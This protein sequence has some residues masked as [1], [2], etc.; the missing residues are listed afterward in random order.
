[1]TPHTSPL[2]RAVDEMLLDAGETDARLRATLLSLG[3]LASLPV[4]EPRAD[5]AALLA[6]QPSLLAR[7]RL[8]RSRRSAAVGL[9]VI[10]GM[11]LGVTGVAATG[12]APNPHASRSIQHLMQDWAPSWTVAGTPAALGALGDAPRMP[13]AE[14][15]VPEASVPDGSGLDES[16]PGGPVPALSDA[17]DQ[18]TADLGTPGPATGVPGGVAQENGQ[19]RSKDPGH[20]AS[21]PGKSASDGGASRNSAGGTNGG[22]ASPD[23]TGPIRQEPGAV[24]GS[25]PANQLEK[26][27]KLVTKAPAVVGSLTS[28]L[29]APVTTG[30]STTHPV[31]TEKTGAG[32]AGPGSLW[33]KKF[34]R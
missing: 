9:A 33:L 26:A 29:L 27:G 16:V 4:P 23:G 8:R 5:L 31:T 1:L 3:A 30:A 2:L 18:S 7:H 24:P 6:P 28:G 10:A 32:S 25:N 12:S 19:G 11:G 20:G 21:S 22:G 14:L 13:A 34:S 17:G 15:E